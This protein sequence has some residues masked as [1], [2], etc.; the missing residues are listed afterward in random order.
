M[1]QLQSFF[2]NIFGVVSSYIISIGILQVLLM[3]NIVSTIINFV[4]F[5]SLLQLLGGYSFLFGK[6]I[7]NSYLF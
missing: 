5:P 3:K 7:E 2:M 4:L 1:S 6:C